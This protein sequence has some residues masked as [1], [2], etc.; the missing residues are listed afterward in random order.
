[1]LFPPLY[2]ITVCS[3]TKTIKSQNKFII[4]FKVGCECIY[5]ES[6]GLSR[7]YEILNITKTHVW[8]KEN[9]KKVTILKFCKDNFDIEKI[10]NK[11]IILI[12]KLRFDWN[13]ETFQEH[14]EALKGGYDSS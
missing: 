1:M 12:E 3:V 8:F 5:N 9:N 6:N 11:D 2:D 13:H 14:Y 7:I 4:Q 10:T